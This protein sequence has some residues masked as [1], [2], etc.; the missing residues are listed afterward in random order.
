MKKYLFFATFI[1]V[2]IFGACTKEVNVQSVK[3][4]PTALNLQIGETSQLVATITPSDA[5]NKNVVWK[6]S[7]SSIASVSEDGLVSAITEGSCDITATVDNVS[8]T[9][10]VT[11]TKAIIPVTSVTLEPTSANIIEGETIQ[12][13]AT[14]LPND[15]SEQEVLWSSSNDGV[16]T[17]EKGLVTGI[18]QGEVTITAAAGDKSATC[19]ITVEKKVVPVSSISLNTTTGSL[20]IGETIQLTATVLPSDATDN[21]VTWTSS[22]TDVATVDNGLV[23]AI[24]AGETTITATAGECSASCMVTVAA[25]FS[26]SGMCMEA[27]NSASMSISNP[28]GLTIEYKVENNDWASSNVTSISIRA[29]AGERVWFRGHN[30]SYSGVIFRNTSGSFYLYGN[31]MSLI[32]GDDFEDKKELTGE[33]TFYKLFFDNSGIYNHPTKDIELPASTLTTSCYRNMFYKCPNLTRAPKLPA[34]ILTEA[35]YASMFAYCTSIKEFPEMAATDMAYMSC[36]W[37][38][39]GSGIEEAPELPAMNLAQSCY[40]FMFME[41]PNLKNA[42]SVLPATELA[43]NC[44]TGMFQRADKLENAPQLPATDLTY[45][46]YSHMFNGCKALK[47]AP[48]LPATKLAEACYQRMFGNTLLTEAPELPA[49]DMEVMCYQYMFQ[50]CTELEKAPVLPATQLNYWCYEYMFSGCSKLSYIK[51]LF[52]TKPSDRYTPGWVE[53][54][55][56]KGTF[57]KNPEATWDVRGVNGIPEGWTVE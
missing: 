24:S 27:I 3:I 47:N 5:T 34:K 17:I 15:A 19:K 42:M 37:M 53:G 2:S 13:K 49:T 41:C 4:S 7:S 29:N 6:S 48:K 32:Y 45:S 44:Y 51:A 35:C 46:C 28:N 20:T 43:P 18:S 26:Y 55:A 22:N 31:L 57:V 10:K 36:T 11:V 16:A 52:L 23:T 38:M 54:V 56:E 40:E 8:A 30:N 14:V 21:T 50:N 25:P 9:C 33:E 12:L 39:M 1:V